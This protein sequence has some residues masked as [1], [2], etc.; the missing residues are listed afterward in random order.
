MAQSDKQ[1]K[2]TKLRIDDDIERAVWVK[3]AELNVPLT[4]VLNAMLRAWVEGQETI[5]EHRKE[6]VGPSGKGVVQLLYSLG[7]ET[8]NLM[9]QIRDAASQLKEIIETDGRNSSDART[10][11]E[12]TGMEEGILREVVEVNHSAGAAIEYATPRGRDAKGA[13]PRTTGAG[14][15]GRP[16]KAK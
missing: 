1:K 2:G 8:E 4:R 9:H 11:P 7:A 6:R 3:C 12:R 5:Y 16:R 14:G 10:S 13:D 15:I